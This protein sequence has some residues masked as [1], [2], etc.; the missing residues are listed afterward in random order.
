MTTPGVRVSHLPEEY[1][2]EIVGRASMGDEPEFVH[3]LLLL[4]Q[5]QE[6]VSEDVTQ[7]HSQYSI[8]PYSFFNLLLSLYPS[9]RL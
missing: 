3:V 4:E 5:D 1:F 8:L 7:I 2:S 9:I 6:F